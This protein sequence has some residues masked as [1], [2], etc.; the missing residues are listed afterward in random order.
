MLGKTTTITRLAMCLARY[1]K[2][3]GTVLRVCKQ[4]EKKC[5]GS[6]NT[7]YTIDESGE[8][9][10]T[11]DHRQDDNASRA[12][13]VLDREGTLRQIRSWAQ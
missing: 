9:G 4:E 5:N 13:G 10:A 1:N 2:D 7:K 8:G 12:D 6:R 11:Q 3:E